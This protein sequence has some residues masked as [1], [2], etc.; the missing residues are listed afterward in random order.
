[1]AL[2]D[3]DISDVVGFVN[4]MGGVLDKMTAKVEQYAEAFNGADENGDKSGMENVQAKLSE[5]AE[6]AAEYHETLLDMA[7]WLRENASELGEDSEQVL[8]DITDV[9]SQFSS[10][11]SDATYLAGEANAGSY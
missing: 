9:G 3:Y 7:V 6:D 8:S 11:I 2:Q 1:M 5:V 4:G 10:L